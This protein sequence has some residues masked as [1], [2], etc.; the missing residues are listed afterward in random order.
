MK[1]LFWFR[2]SESK[3]QVKAKDPVGSIQCRI[4]IQNSAVELGSTGISCK[5]SSWNP[6]NQTLRGDSLRATRA[7]KVIRDTTANLEKLFDMLATKY[8][9]VSPST[10]K[11]YYLSKKK[12]TYS[13]TEIFDAWNDHRRKLAEKGSISPNTFE[14]HENYLRH[15]GEYFKVRGVARPIEIPDNFF[16]DF[17]DW[18]LMADRS[19]E[20]FARKVSEFAK[21]VFTWAEKKR[22][23]H[24]LQACAEP[25][26][27]KAD[28]EENLD[29]THLTVPQLTKLISFDFFK[30]VAAGQIVSQT[31]ETLSVERDAFVFNCFTGM[32]HCDYTKKDF[33]I[34]QYKAATFL[35]GH[36]QKTKKR[37]AI[38]LLEPAIAILNKYGGDYKN[39]P[40]KSNQKRNASL[41]QIAAFAGLP[42]LLS[43][44][45]ARKTFADIALNV[46]LMTP[47]DVAQCLGLTSTRYLKNYV[48]IREERLLKVMPSWANLQ[49]AC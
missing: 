27:G 24:R 13:I 19:G 5:K 21:Q 2:K 35:T 16:Q 12:F 36:R 46:M 47:D 38:K 20:R 42:I 4:T 41:K 15:I 29:T 48:R 44:K 25:L 7:N 49:E 22:L 31:A 17:Y 11:D 10:L 3:E 26:P 30:L 28:T 1:I 45:I 39:L 6:E 23:C 8:S 14:V 34:E 33:H 9:Y 18:M 37:F 43:T 32:H 40:V